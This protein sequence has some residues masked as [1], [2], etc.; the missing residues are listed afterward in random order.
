MD[1]VLITIYGFA[2]GTDMN[3]I[4]NKMQIC[5]VSRHFKKC[6]VAYLRSVQSHLKLRYGGSCDGPQEGT[7]VRWMKRYDIASLF[8][9]KAWIYSNDLDTF[10]RDFADFDFSNLNELE[11][12][13]STMNPGRYSFFDRVHNIHSLFTVAA[14]LTH[15]T[16]SDNTRHPIESYA[17]F[18]SSFPILKSLEVNFGSQNAADPD[19]VSRAS[20]KALRLERLLLHGL[21]GDNFTLCSE[22]LKI[23]DL[24][25]CV[26]RS[27][28][29]LD[30]PSLE[31]LVCQNPIIIG[32]ISG[33]A[34]AEEYGN[35][36]RD[37]ITSFL[38]NVEHQVHSSDVESI[39]S[40]SIVPFDSIEGNNSIQVG[41]DC[42][43]IIFT[44][45]AN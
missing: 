18:L 40:I 45:S 42:R 43:I 26:L 32:G 8:G 7:I 1:E 4:V 9:L 41:S 44:F 29:R 6:F 27:I 28:A 2:L 3:T 24:H 25:T 19:G 15:L 31:E 34:L 23:L 30:C 10:N 35:S 14:S 39:A 33:S 22:S 5:L 13:I 11:L 36:D 17:N 21:Y 16:L 12:T 38:E 37:F 20:E